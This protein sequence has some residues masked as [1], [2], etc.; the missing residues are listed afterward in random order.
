MKLIVGL[1]NPGEEY[2]HT[3]HNI[4]F[5]VVDEAAQALGVRL[6]RR[7]YQSLFT[8]TSEGP[9]R[10]GFMK[11]MTYMNRSGE[12]V[13]GGVKR[14]GVALH[15]L[16][17]VH[18]DLDLELGAL[19]LAFD[20]GAAGHR[21]IIS[22]HECLGSQAYWR[23]RVGVGRPPRGADAAEYVLHVFPKRERQ[24]VDEMVQQAVEA[25]LLFIREGP[26]V[27]QRQFHRKGA[28]AKENGNGTA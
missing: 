21:G 4:G 11:P 15:D 1:G 6:T 28:E 10:I 12:A 24:L 9:L 13:A 3:R 8:S 23:L 19:K 25:V 27:V 2:G 5:R 14:E 22:T 16:L 20:R 7:L 17:V 18:D 26:E